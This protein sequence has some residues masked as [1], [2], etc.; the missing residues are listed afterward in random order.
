M[1]TPVEGTVAR[2]P[3]RDSHES[4]S[5]ELRTNPD[6]LT[7]INLSAETQSDLDSLAEETTSCKMTRGDLARMLKDNT[8]TTRA[9]MRAEI[10]D[11]VLADTRREL[12]D[13]FQASVGACESDMQDQVWQI[14]QLKE[15]LAYRDEEREAMVIDFDKMKATIHQLDAALKH[16]GSKYEEEITRYREAAQQAYAELAMKQEAPTATQ[17]K[18]AAQTTTYLISDSPH[19]VGLNRLPLYPPP[20]LGGYTNPTT[21]LAREVP[22]PQ[23]FTFHG[24]GAPSVSAPPRLAPSSRGSEDGRRC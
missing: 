21:S 18:P 12:E 7:A 4:R 5:E 15:N 11:S 8:E 2:T 22:P 16:Q 23:P 14:K 1:T 6:A 10:Y 20:G 24:T 17:G 3:S 13:K 9:T 19:P